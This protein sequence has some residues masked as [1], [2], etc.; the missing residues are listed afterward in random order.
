MRRRQGARGYRIGEPRAHARTSVS[1]WSRRLHRRRQHPLGGRAPLRCRTDGPARTGKG[2]RGVAH[3]R[4]S[5]NRLTFRDVAAAIGDHL[6]L[7]TVSVAP[8]N[9]EAHFGWIGHF[10]GMDIAAT[11]THTQNLLGWTPSGPTLFEDIAAGAY[12]L[13]E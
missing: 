5:R 3:A 10:F 6:G 4:G 8:E 13:P 11:S 12:A 9:A 2:A 1:W 7:P